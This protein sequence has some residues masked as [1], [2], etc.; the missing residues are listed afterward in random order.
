[1]TTTQSHRQIC[2]WGGVNVK[3]EIPLRLQ[4]PIS[5]Y[6]L[7]YH[8]DNI[9]LISALMSMEPQVHRVITGQEF[10]QDNLRV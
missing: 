7:N 10:V 1:M 4:L 9:T 8:V 5:H 6:K 2:R 3:C